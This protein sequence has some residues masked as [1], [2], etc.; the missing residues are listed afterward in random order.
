MRL[1]KPLTIRFIAAA[2]AALAL[3]LAGIRAAEAAPPAKSRLVANLEAGKPQHLVIYG[4]SLSK[5]GAW[6]TQLQAALDARFPG[7]LT[8]TN[9]AKGGQN[10]RWGLENVESN[11]IAHKPDTVF[12]EFA[13]NDAVTRFNLSL[14]EVRANVD[15]M[16]DRITRALP[17]CEIIL[18]VMNPAVGKA[19]GDPSHRRNQDAYQQ[20]YRDAAKRRGLR[21]I[22]HCIAWNA[23]LAA[24]GEAGFKRYVPDG[25][26][27]NAEGY[28][29]FVTPTILAAI[30][31]PAAQARN[32]SEPPRLNGRGYDSE[33]AASIKTRSSDYDVVVY[34]GTSGGVTAAV[35][36]ARGGAKV[37]LLES[38]YLIGGLMTGG[39]TKTD[40][41]K[42]ETIGGLAREFYHRVLAYYTKTYGAGSEQ[43]KACEGGY[44]FEPSVALKIFNAMLAEAG[45]TVRT[46]EQLQSVDVR[47]HRV[48]AIVTR[49]Y[50]TGAESQFT[51]KMFIDGSY[52]GDLMA[53]AGA[54]YRVGREARV[55]YNES[56]AGLTEG[57]K[58]YLGTGDHR[59]QAFNIRG[60]LTIRD[61]L[62]LP[63]PKPRHYYRDAHAY[64]ISIVNEHKL[65]RLDELFTDTI[66]WAMINGKCDPNKA[67]FPGVQFGYAEGDYE[68]RARIT[69]LVQD[70]WL[71]LWYMLQNDPEL[72]E[73]FKAD[74]RRWGLPKDEYVESGHV[75]P[76]VYVRV[77]RRLQG[78]YLLT[79]NDVRYD[80][81]KP[82]SVCLGSYN[83]DCHVI[84]TIWTDRGP[85]GEGMFNG[86][87]DPWEI[88][89]RS[90]LPHGID[91]L[92]V[93][94][95]ISATHVAYSSLRMEPVFMMLGHAGGLAAH[96]ALADKTSMQDVSISKLQAKLGAD[97]MPL[98]APYRPW[99]EI[100]AVTPPPHKPGAPIE[101]EVI[102][103]DVRAPLTR[104]AWNFDGSGEVQAEGR[105]VR[106][107]FSQG[108]RHTIM[109]LTGDNGRVPALPALL[110]ID[111]G[112]E[113][114]DR[115][116]NYT[117]A[118]ITG[119]WIRARGPE[120]EYRDRVGLLDE[121]K[122]DGQSSA[123]FTATLPRTG[124]YRVAI[125]YA[126]GPNRAT[127]A[128]ITVAHAGGTAT[129]LLNEQKK[130][131]PY[132]FAPIGEYHFNAGES[133]SVTFTNQGSN[134]A[135]M[136]DSVRWIWVGE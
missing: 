13:I 97:G 77:A 48:R 82:D 56:L 41:G 15:S 113:S 110:D 112:G 64:L 91:N 51:A 10:S 107:T 135:V 104:L 94:A 43:V 89:Y 84:Q 57:P 28:A 20:I 136:V 131:S 49:H 52:E 119:R 24:E 133:A 72:P 134:G 22:D 100:H 9:G 111:L 132:A 44:Y 79:Q 12:I 17:Q 47:D 4:T 31:I 65:T 98:K 128:P 93:V 86:S 7:L 39:L 76:Q 55:E 11:V 106:H 126:T 53:Q 121:A 36:A 88:P 103:K 16:L 81:F 14:D 85:I 90:L 71:S 60:T 2:V 109:L 37:L 25:V 96:F 33:V 67:D 35:A 68:Q 95:A 125:A 8:L 29:R 1:P 114:L 58:E 75:T 18:Q 87:A 38:S 50:E 3:G 69:A 63:I 74:A 6:V 32:D 5:G 27:P 115:E 127:N 78:R 70:Y 30:G 124:R 21:L 129:V 59:V 101:F 83:T 116:V 123:V 54:L 66:R 61:D 19:E 73:A 118:K 130:T 122:G 46:K 99:V 62:R 26:H 92:V 45:V 105:R 120:I 80:R 102:E 40:I 42:A 108:G 117:Q 23:L 34:G